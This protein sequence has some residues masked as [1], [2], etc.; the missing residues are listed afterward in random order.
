M[1][2]TISGR[3]SGNTRSDGLSQQRGATKT[4]PPNLVPR[5]IGKGFIRCPPRSRATPNAAHRPVLLTNPALGPS[6]TYTLKRRERLVPKPQAVG[7][8]AALA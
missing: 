8:R 6:Y 5:G 4:P 2:S 1:P 3:L 7:C